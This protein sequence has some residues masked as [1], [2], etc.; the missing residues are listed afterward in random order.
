MRRL[1]MAA[2]GAVVSA[3]LVSGAQEGDW[4]AYGRDPG[5]ERFSPLDAIQRDNVGSLQVAWTFRTGDAFVPK[6]GRP[7]AFEATPLLRRR[8]CST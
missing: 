4:A 2:L 8:H 5:G 7:T 3:A 6:E 1:G